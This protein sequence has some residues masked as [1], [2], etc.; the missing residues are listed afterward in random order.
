MPEP[1]IPPPAPELA[2]EWLGRVPYAEALEFQ[3]KRVEAR[4]QGSAGDVLLLL[5]H[6]PVVT[7]GRGACPENLLETPEALRARGIEVHE[8]ARGGDVT[9]HGPGQL[10]GYLVL[11]LE[12]RGR[13]D[14]HAHLRGIES[15]LIDALGA[16]GIA[17]GRRE[18]MTGVFV[19][20]EDPAAPGTP[21][22]IASIGVGLRGWVTYHGFALNV[23][24]GPEAFAGIVPC[25]L[26]GVRMTSVIE[27]RPDGL[28]G[29]ALL[30]A[31]RDAV[32]TAA[33]RRLASA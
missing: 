29:A 17:G 23:D 7:L 14:V 27:E 32:S 5:E 10:V 12:A 15:L 24:P 11:D 22:K 25:G 19:E 16:L 31:S 1:A 26:H 13:P 18:G 20:P 6:P 8:V 2:I 4:R 21:R 33:R 9:W 30:E 3:R 28:A